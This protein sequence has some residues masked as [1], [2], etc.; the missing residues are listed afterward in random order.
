MAE[1]FVIQDVSTESITIGFIFKNPSVLSEYLELIFPEYDFNDMGLRFLYNLLIDTYLNHTEI[2][3]TSVNIQV[4]KMNEEGQLLYKS[5]GGFK[6]YQRLAVISETQTDF[7]NVYEKLKTYNILRHLHKKGFS[8]EK[9]FDK[10]KDKSVEDILK[11]YEYQL[12]K[13]NSYI[14]G[15]N[16]S[17]RLGSDIIDTYENLKETPDV[18]I[19]LP[20]PIIDSLARG[21]RTGKLYASAMHSGHG[22]SR[23]MVFVLAY[24]SIIN[25]I[26]TLLCINEQEKS[27]I[28]LMLLTCIANNVFAPKYGVFVNETDIALGNCTGEKNKMVIEA[29][30]FIKERSK[31]QLLELQAWDFDSLKM[32]LK[33]HKIRGINYCCIDTFKPMRG[34]EMKG[35]NEW[36]QFSYTA[37]NL[38][39]IIG[40]EAKGGLDMGLWITMQ[41]TDD[42]IT[43]KTLNSTAIASSKHTKHHMDYLQMSRKLDFQDKSKIKVRIQ[44]K[45][46]AFNGQ[47][48]ALPLNKTHYLTFVEKNRSGLDHKNLIY[49]VDN[50]L[51]TWKELGYAV[52]NHSDT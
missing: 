7:K 23:M 17:I 6:I 38:K 11:V 25:Q 24:T 44:I 43:T 16:D 22:K 13:V 46:N 29:A 8:I 39:K 18:G 4:S 19:P 10:L 36:Q 41:L 14:K 31:I 15:I 49:E 3:E 30:N 12:L 52:F 26:P 47:V 48:E 33:K 35:M 27:E 50:G 21:W 37:E 20:F 51:M 1:E 2:N 45:D 40:S 28:D 5:L 42:S 32:I 34:I 9:N